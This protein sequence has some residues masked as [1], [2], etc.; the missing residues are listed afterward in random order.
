M[1]RPSGKW[2]SLSEEGRGAVGI[3]SRFESTRDAL[4]LARERRSA[5]ART[6]TRSVLKPCGSYLE[7]A[8]R[9]LNLVSRVRVLDRL[10]QVPTSPDHDKQ[11][12][13]AKHQQ[14]DEAG[15]GEVGR[16]RCP[17]VGKGDGPS[18]A[19]FE[20]SAVQ[21]DPGVPRAGG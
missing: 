18:C 1:V 3:S 5:G 7:G 4:P 11:G 17:G 20:Q 19:A 14:D 21:S 15:D 13:D 9:S 12:C 8:G 2:P 10:K 16:V 6:E